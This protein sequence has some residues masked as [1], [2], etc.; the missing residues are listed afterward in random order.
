MKR[1][2]VI[3]LT[4]DDVG[5]AGLILSSLKNT[6]ITNDILCFEN[7]EDTLDFLFKRGR[8]PYREDGV[9]YVLLLDIRLPG[10]D[11]TEVLH[12]IKNDK[13]VN[14]IPVIMLSVSDNPEEIEKCRRLGCNNY[15]VKHTTYEKFH[16]TVE[17]LGLYINQVVFPDIAN[18]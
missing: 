14:K 17:Q 2:P 10:I 9:L 3:I 18:A 16:L 12:R 5:H 8:E 13:W 15:F 6:G 7:G 1:D 11:G 4:E